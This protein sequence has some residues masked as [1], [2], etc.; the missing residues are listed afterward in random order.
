MKKKRDESIRRIR[1][2]SLA[3]TIFP[4]L[5]EL[6]I[7]IPASEAAIS[8]QR[9]QKDKLALPK[10][11]IQDWEIDIPKGFQSASE[12]FFLLGVETA[13]VVSRLLSLLHQHNRVARRLIN[14]LTEEKTFSRDWAVFQKREIFSNR[15]KLMHDLAEEAQELVGKIADNEMVPEYIMEPIEEP[16]Y[17]VASDYGDTDLVDATKT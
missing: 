14:G 3:H 12:L 1:A 11:K 2:H 5:M 10:H 8:S 9:A 4:D 16:E 17:K 13:P 15:F 6:A 7:K